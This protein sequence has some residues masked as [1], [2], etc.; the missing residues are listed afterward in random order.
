MMRYRGKFQ[1]SSYSMISVT[2]DD[3]G[4]NLEQK[5]RTWVEMEK[6]KR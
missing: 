1:R 4:A 6:W 3:E 5:W 2:P